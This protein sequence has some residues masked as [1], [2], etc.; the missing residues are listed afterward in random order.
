MGRNDHPAWTATVAMERL[1]AVADPKDLLDQ[2]Q[3]EPTPIVV[4]ILGLWL[5]D[6]PEY[7]TIYGLL[8]RIA[9]DNLGVGAALAIAR[10]LRGP[11]D[12]VLEHTNDGL[13][14]SCRMG[15]SGMLQ[16]RVFAETE[17]MAVLA[18]LV[19]A[20]MEEEKA[21]DQA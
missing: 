9:A 12:F 15:I 17:T 1:R 10:I 19:S 4:N 14:I 2:L 20:L 5:T 11:C 16:D 8:Q 21:G 18:A 3:H 6:H 7:P 13:T